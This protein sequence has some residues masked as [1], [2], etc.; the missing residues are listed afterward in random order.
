MCVKKP[1][2]M[3]CPGCMQRFCPLAEWQYNKQ[4]WT[5]LQYT[6]QAETFL[7]AGSAALQPQRDVHS[8]WCYQAIG[9]AEENASLLAGWC[10]PSVS[11][12]VLHRLGPHAVQSA[13][14]SLQVGGAGE[15]AGVGVRPEH[16]HGHVAATPANSM[17]ADTQVKIRVGSCVGRP[18][19]AFLDCFP[20][21]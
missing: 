3:S 19:S 1:C 6:A 9:A 4:P 14:L 21:H 17:A 15:G 20:H 2:Y 7:Q 16:M 18:P 8:V 11:P 5:L 10:A 13:R 12:G